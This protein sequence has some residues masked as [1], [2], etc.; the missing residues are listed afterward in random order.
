M[1]RKH[2]SGLFRA[3]AIL[4]ALGLS[5]SALAQEDDWYPSPY[6]AEDEI[7]ALNLLGPDDVRRGAGLVRQG[8]VFSLGVITGADT[9]AYG[10]RG[11]KMTMIPHDDRPP[12]GAMKGTSHD[13]MLETSLGIGSQ[14]DG[15]A[16]LGINHRYY[17]GATAEEIYA[18]DGA[19]KFGTENIPPIAT[20][21]ILLD[22]AALRD[23]PL[24]RGEEITV[25]DIEAAAK[26]AKVSI[27][28]GDVVLFHTGWMRLAEEDP[29]TFLS[30]APGIGVP[31]AEWLAD[32]GVVAVGADTW[33]VEVLPNPD[34][35]QVFPVHSTLLA[36]RGVH[37]LESMDTAALAEDGPG[38][39]FF[40]LG[41]P[42]FEGAVQMVINPVAMR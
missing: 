8:K 14:I 23:R 2:T 12:F 36:K 1:N 40:V 30:G 31:A 18:P 5:A 16:H 15:F 24:E 22:I 11:F 20:R 13:D 33:C 25:E 41:V 9:P 26:A 39:F 28:H 38:P 37:L 10:D 19:K 34:P 3:A 29:Q 35:A 4:C 32:R 6:G 21:G 17:N 27:K 42:R 7:G